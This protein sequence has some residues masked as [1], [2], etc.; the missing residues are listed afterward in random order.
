VIDDQPR[1]DEM[2]PAVALRAF[3]VILVVVLLALAGIVMLT[4]PTRILTEYACERN[5]AAVDFDP[6]LVRSTDLRLKRTW[7]RRT[8]APNEWELKGPPPL[9]GTST[10]FPLNTNSI[11]GS[12]GIQWKSADGRT[13]TAFLSF[14]DIVGERGPY[15]VWLDVSDDSSRTYKGA[16]YGG[17]VRFTCGPIAQ[18][19]L[20]G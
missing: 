1:D 10:T 13:R 14:S 17:Y 4:H 8:Q 18:K 3:L 7:V 9:D 12:E 15:T 2:R 6:D 5:H 19:R 20:A 11:G 16:A